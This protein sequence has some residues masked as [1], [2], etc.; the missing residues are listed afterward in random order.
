MGLFQRRHAV[1]ESNT[2]AA[3]PAAPEP[4]TAPEPPSAAAPEAT[5]PAVAPPP[6]V[7]TAPMPANSPQPPFGLS[8]FPLLPL[9]TALWT[10]AAA[11]IVNLEAAVPRLPDSLVVLGGPT[12]QGVALIVGGRVTDA[13]WVN[14]S[15]GLLGDGAAHAV[16]TSLEG[17]L[18]AYR[19][20]DP[21]LATA[22]PM[23]WRSPQLGSGVPAGWLHTDDIVAEVRTSGRSCGLL[24]ELRGPGG[25]AVRGWR[26]VRR[27]H[28]EPPVAGHLDHDVAQPA[29]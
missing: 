12:S 1:A 26:A 15:G 18:T 20:D 2:Q 16:M 9:G 29:P 10:D 21:R 3:Q 11:N 8:D 6:V 27:V 28:H 5:A 19:I 17:T 7:P 4:A 14:G 25:G 23:L 22:L 13:V 24:V